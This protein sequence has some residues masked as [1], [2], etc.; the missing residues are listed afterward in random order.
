VTLIFKVLIP[1][2]AEI[3]IFAALFILAF[4]F[5]VDDKCPQSDPNCSESFRR[6]KRIQNLL[7]I[8]LNYALLLIALIFWY[9][10]PYKRTTQ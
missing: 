3:F 8:I 7:P 10:L 2:A 5:V 1:A 6:E 9:Y 4:S